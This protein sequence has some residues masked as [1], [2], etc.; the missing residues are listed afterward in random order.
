MAMLAPYS[1]KRLVGATDPASTG[2][3]VDATATGATVTGFGLYSQLTAR[4]EV[5]GVSGGA[6][7]Y[8]C[9]IQTQLGEDWIDLITFTQATGAT[10][11][12]VIVQRT[13]ATSWSNRLRVVQTIGA[14]A[15]A[16]GVRLTLVG[17][18]G[19]GE[20]TVTVGDIT[21]VSS[22]VKAATGTVTTV[23]DTG[24]TTTLLAANTSREGVQVHNNSTSVLYVKY[25]GAASIAGGGYT[26]KIPAD[27]HW[28]MPGPSIYTGVLHA[29]WSANASGYANIT[30][31]TA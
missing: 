29:I 1:E 4:L 28:E 15:T 23:D 2:A 6:D 11:E 25:G 8:D 26:V 24:S 19:A 10:D 16:T 13:E 7:T 21:A 31:L 22:P 27:G 30:E 14:S 12:T 5:G 17:A 20:A 9:K 3:T 18:M